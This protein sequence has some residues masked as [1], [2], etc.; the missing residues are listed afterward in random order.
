MTALPSYKYGDP[1]HVL[2]AKESAVESRIGK[3][4]GCKHLTF[5]ASGDRIFASCDR[6]RK[7]GRKGKCS[8][9]KES[10]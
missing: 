5:D 8:I 9:R 3:C 1:L 2:I 6:A 7:V 10:E 4:K